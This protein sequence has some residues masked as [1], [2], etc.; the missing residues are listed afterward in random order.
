[1]AAKRLGAFEE[2]VVNRVRPA[3]LAIEDIEEDKTDS[4]MI[5]RFN[6]IVDVCDEC[7]GDVEQFA[8]A[9]L[10]DDS[11]SGFTEEDAQKCTSLSNELSTF[12][13]DS[14]AMYFKTNPKNADAPRF[15]V[16][17]DTSEKVLV[18]AQQGILWVARA[19]E[20]MSFLQP[21]PELAFDYKRWALLDGV[22]QLLQGAGD[23]VS[24]L[25]KWFDLRVQEKILSCPL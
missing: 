14:L 1:M 18:E 24:L 20:S 16:S 9:R 10:H 22:A 15:I 2:V 3:M 25:R 5:V 12:V 13:E 7:S 4:I 11:P 21:C 6:A 23:P 8:K 17:A 19:I